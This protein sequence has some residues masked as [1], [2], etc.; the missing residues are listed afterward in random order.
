MAIEAGTGTG[1][2]IAY[3]I[4]TL[5]VARQRDRRL[6]ISTATLNLQE[7]LV[8][9]D[10]PD[11]A[12]HAQLPFTYELAKG[13]GR[14]VCPQR[15][16]TRASGG[17][18]QANLPLDLLALAPADSSIDYDDLLDAFISGRWN[19]EREA[20]SVEVADPDWVPVTTD[21]RGCTGRRCKFFKQCPYFLARQ[22]IDVADVIVANHDL[23]LADLALGGGAV[24][25][26]PEQAIYV[27]DEAHHLAT[28]A[29][30]HFSL[31][32][33][34]GGSRAWLDT[35][36]AALGTMSQQLGRPKELMPLVE[37]VVAALPD[38][39]DQL[40]GLEGLLAEGFVFE[41]LSDGRR[42]SRFEHG[43]PP[44]GLV[45]LAGGLA[46]SFLTI[47]TPL[48]DVAALLESVLDE[49]VIW[50]K[51]SGAEDWFPVA[52]ALSKRAADIAALLL[53]LATQ[54]IV[55]ANHRERV[56]LRCAEKYQGRTWNSFQFLWRW[57][58]RWR[59][60]CGVAATLP[61]SRPPR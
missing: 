13:R 28:K 48:D 15:L 2:T 26:A 25:P 12:Q 19:G 53:T 37:R 61:F 59:M 11:L 14:Y 50:P 31:S 29:Q 30:S 35:V 16:A 60:F 52:G 43:A 27:F 8:T 34:V 36:N 57:V 46:S 32:A 10:L 23:V 51:G 56:G 3:L 21:H 22:R 47:V 17:G 5:P 49:K 7:Q 45:E 18:E 6:I 40:T 42:V 1:K 54:S 41:S 55:P 4:A 9:K 38:L 58:A 33:S 20:L 44:P 39:G 24:L